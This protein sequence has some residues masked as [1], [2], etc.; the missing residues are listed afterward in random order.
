MRDLV[1]NAKRGLAILLAVATLLTCNGISVY[2]EE[3]GTNENGVYTE[4]DG[5]ELSVG[6]SDEDKEDKEAEEQIGRA[7]V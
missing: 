2:A 4:D 3:L 1:L 7:H 5:E 6:T